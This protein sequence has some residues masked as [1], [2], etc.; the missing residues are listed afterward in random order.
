M[1]QTQVAQK[2]SEE[3]SG[4]LQEYVS[5]C[6]PLEVPQLMVNPLS[7]RPTSLKVEDEIKQIFVDGP[8]KS[9]VFSCFCFLFLLSFTD[10]TEQQKY[11]LFWWDFLEQ[12]TLK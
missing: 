7:S 4:N 3:M 8:K 11:V 12:T 1:A 2:E 5:I 10:I 6:I 9:V